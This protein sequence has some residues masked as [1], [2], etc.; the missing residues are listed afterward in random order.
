[1]DFRRAVAAAVLLCL[2]LAPV[3]S[4]RERGEDELRRDMEFARQQVYPALVNISVLVKGYGGGRSQRVPAAGSGVIVSPAGHVITNYHVAGDAARIVCRLPSREAVEATVVA[5]DPLTDISILKLKLETRK[6]RNIPI[7]FAR[8]G[9]SDELTTGDYVLA[10]GNPLALSSSMTLG[11]VSNPQRVFSSFTGA[12][13]DELD[14]GEGQLTG[15]FTRWIQ[16]DALIL[17]GNSGGPLVNLKGEVVGINE[18]GGNG[19]G[20]AIPSNL[21]SHVLNQALTHG[22]VVRGWFGI[23]LYPV[24]KMDREHGV[25]VA[26]VQR[27]GPAALAGIEP[28]DVILA[29][30]GKAADAVYFEEIPVL[31]KRLADYTPGAKALVS[32][33]RGAEPKQVTV[34]VARMEP[35]LADERELKE[36]GLTARDITGPMA[37]L[38]RYPS[39]DGVLVTGVRPGLPAEAAKPGLGSGDVLLAFD[40]EP[41]KDFEGLRTAVAKAGKKEGILV[42]FRRKDERMVTVLD[43]SVKPKPKAGG[44]LPKAWLGI[45]TQV[46]TAE[47]AKG[48]GLG[49]TKGFRITQV[50]PGT[51]AE[52]AGLAVGDVITG[53]NGEPLRAYRPQDAEILRRKVESLVIGEKARFTLLREGGE[54]EIEVVLEETPQTAAEVKTAADEVLEYKV[55]GITFGDR[56]ENRWPQDQKGVVVTEVTMGG[57]AFLAGLSTGDLVTKIDGAEIADIPAFEAAAKRIA[58][59]KPKVVTIFV[60]RGYR[61]AFVFVRPEFE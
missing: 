14:L 36:L 10:M 43:T 52:K 18:L 11:I 55:R 60:T 20:F 21:V 45:R 37:L 3:A 50:F 27:G 7:P 12:E 38:R 40:G 59:T 25:L 17:P 1:M 46:L 57:W 61:T 2:A 48:L 19:V 41:V 35:Y 22:D 39:P 47:V 15:T 26:D 4:G 33:L 30:D 53:L 58:E 9:D 28:G 16:H 24:E 8:I 5:H 31:Y 29:L 13:M 34:E 54:Q 51:E 44:E 42:Q 56:V 6:D 49:S 23:T 32:L